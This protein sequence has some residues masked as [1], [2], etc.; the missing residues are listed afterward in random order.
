MP[1]RAKPVLKRPWIHHVI[2]ICYIAAPFANILLVK[3]FLGVSFATIF[4]NLLN[5]YGILA[6][7]WLV[8]APIVG[9]SLY[10]VKRF[11]WYVFLGHSGLIL[12][13]FVYKWATRPAYYLR[14][15][16]GTHNILLLAGNIALV[17]IVAYIIQKDF[18][19]PYFQILNR[20][21]RERTRI[22]V[23]HAVAID[24]E[25]RIM[26]DLSDGGCFVSWP[27]ALGAPGSRVMLSFQS[28]TL[29]I[30]CAGEVMRVTDKGIGIRFLHLPRA[31]RRDIRWLIRNRFS[32]RHQVDIPCVSLFGHEESQARMVDVSPTGCYVRSQSAGLSAGSTGSLK[33][34]LTSRHPS[35]S[36]P[37]SVV[38]TNQG[39]VCVKPAGF[40]FRF[41]HR[42]SDFA[43]RAAIQ[44]GQG[45]LVR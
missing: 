37:G 31:K 5:G 13:D 26:S 45:V 36:L 11:S 42:Q 35:I 3:A 15:V 22:P 33:V 25:S 1:V 17:A 41:D 34:C 23:Y 40:G 6:T 18:R 14:T 44:Y 39:D 16:P 43:R 20:T 9:V 2:I 29:N 21:W 19:A 8:T 28:N 24:G 38:W 10:F 30:E 4:S 7:V 32:L 12:A 27:G